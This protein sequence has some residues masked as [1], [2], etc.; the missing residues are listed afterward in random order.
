MKEGRK[1]EIKGGKK[2]GRIEREEVKEGC[3]GKSEERM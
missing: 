1:E 2:E 3:E